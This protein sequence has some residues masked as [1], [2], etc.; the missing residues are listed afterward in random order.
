MMFIYGE[1][2]NNLFK[3]DRCETIHS[4]QI[5]E[6]NIKA[7]MIKKRENEKQTQLH[8]PLVAVLKVK[9]GDISLQP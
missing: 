2:A 1:T 8:L 5:R 4:N 7:S 6:N 3:H 9:L